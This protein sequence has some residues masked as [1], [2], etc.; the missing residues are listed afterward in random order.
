MTIVDNL[1]F[2]LG[3]LFAVLAVVQMVR[4][5]HERNFNKRWQLAGLLVIGAG[6]FLAIGL[7]LIET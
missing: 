2:A 3:C 5:R 4:M 6:V 1:K 7:G